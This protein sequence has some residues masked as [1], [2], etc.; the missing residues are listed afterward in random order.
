MIEQRMAS[1]LESVIETKLM[2]TNR[3][4]RQSALIWLFVLTKRGSTADLDSVSRQLSR[5]QLA[6]I[7]A[8][9]ES[10]GTFFDNYFNSC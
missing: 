10:N 5:I 8:L 6:F 1:L 3:H 2:H 7:N 4:L 9:A